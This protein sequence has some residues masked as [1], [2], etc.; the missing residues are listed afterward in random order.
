MVL[1]V[2]TWMVPSAMSDDNLGS[3]PPE[4]ENTQHD[5]P[6]AGAEDEESAVDAEDEEPAADDESETA[7]L[8]KARLEAVLRKYRATLRNE[9]E[10]GNEGF[11]LD[12]YQEQKP[13]HW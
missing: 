1:S 9:A 10:A 7:K 3:E 2:R 4:D 6:A 13:P 5:E 11:S 8:K 12:Y